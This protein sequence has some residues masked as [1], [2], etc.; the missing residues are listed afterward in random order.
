M[1]AP[2]VHLHIQDHYVSQVSYFCYFLVAF[3]MFEI[4]ARIDIEV[5]ARTLDFGGQT[6]YYRN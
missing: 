1:S 2:L 4:I 5:S 3:T 6:I